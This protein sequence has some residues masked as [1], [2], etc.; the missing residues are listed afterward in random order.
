M[1]RRSS[2]RIPIIKV[3]PVLCPVPNISGDVLIQISSVWFLPWFPWI[4]SSCQ[5][6]RMPLHSLGWCTEKEQ[7]KHMGTD[8]HSELLLLPFHDF[9]LCGVG[10]KLS[11]IVHSCPLKSFSTLTLQVCA[12][13]S[14]NIFYTAG[15]RLH[16][17][18]ERGAKMTVLQPGSFLRTLVAKNASFS[19]RFTK[20]PVR[21][22]TTKQWTAMEC[23]VQAT[24]SPIPA[25]CCRKGGLAELVESWNILEPSAD[26][27]RRFDLHL[28]HPQTQH[29]PLPVQSLSTGSDGIRVVSRFLACYFKWFL[30]LYWVWKSKQSSAASY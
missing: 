26:A 12:L 19:P 16:Q 6:D 14:F 20:M 9:S 18:E 5:A 2:I 21:N 22:T 8:V 27:S 10:V 29:I 11:I 1:D 7:W 23:T 4:F 3:C 28:K 17:N 25:T 30:V 24:S 15:C 13:C